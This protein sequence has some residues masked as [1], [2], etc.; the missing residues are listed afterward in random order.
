MSSYSF[1]VSDQFISNDDNITL[2]N[3]DID[4][5]DIS[6]IRTNTIKIGNTIEITFDESLSNN[7][8]KT[9][10]N[11]INNRDIIPSIGDYNFAIY[12]MMTIKSPTYQQICKI[13]FR[14]W[15]ITNIE[16]NSYMD[17]GLTNY[18]I[19]LYDPI[20]NQIIFES[21]FTNIDDTVNNITDLQNLPSGNINLELHLKITGGN[22][23]L[24]AHINSIVIYYNI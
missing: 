24:Y 22:N 23:K 14:N 13:P 15:N 8:I 18:L 9:L 19:R 16:I 17:T 4:T 2:V 1:S 6:S 12:P 7:D 11:I 21:T 20:N 10:N 5:S 3:N